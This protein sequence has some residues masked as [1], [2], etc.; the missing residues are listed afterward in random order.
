MKKL[1]SKGQSLVEF[2]IVLPIIL[3][4]IL[5]LLE[6]GLILNSYITINTISRNGARLASVGA[7]DLEINQELIIDAPN[8]DF[9]KVTVT[10]SPNES[11]RL[12]GE[13]V[14][15]DILYKYNVNIPFINLIIGSEVDL[16]SSNSMRIE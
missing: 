16:K 3:V 15:V 6:F 7:S 5:G 14:R 4:L 11:D 9:N 2:T 10:I 13:S 1:N 12:R 8:I